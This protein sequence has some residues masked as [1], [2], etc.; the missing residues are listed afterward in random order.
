MLH[1]D[2]N[3]EADEG[4]D[5]TIFEDDLGLQILLGERIILSQPDQQYFFVTNGDEDVGG[6]N[7]LETF[8]RGAAVERQR[9]KTSQPLGIQ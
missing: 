1:F 3:A 8:Q 5:T 4:H 6:S 2:S 7:L 9:R